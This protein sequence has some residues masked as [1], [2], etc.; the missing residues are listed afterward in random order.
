MAMTA[1]SLLGPDTVTEVLEERFPCVGARDPSLIQISESESL[2][3]GVF[4][5][6]EKP[7][8]RHVQVVGVELVWNGSVQTLDSLRLLR[9]VS[10][11]TVIADR[12]VIQEALEWKGAQVDVFARHLEF[13]GKGSISTVPE[14]FATMAWSEF[15]DSDNDR[16]LNE[17]GEI[18][19]K[20]GRDGQAGGTITLNVGALV[21]P[22]GHTCFITDGAPGE[23]G[24]KGGLRPH[25][26]FK[27]GPATKSVLPVTFD[28]V[29]TA[30]CD[31]NNTHNDLGK[32]SV[33]KTAY[34]VGEDGFKKCWSKVP[35][36]YT[37]TDV[38]LGLQ[39]QQFLARFQ[40]TLFV[41]G[42]GDVD[43]VRHDVT[44]NAVKRNTE[45]FDDMQLFKNTVAPS[46][47]EDAYPSG[48]AGRGGDAG[49]I[50]SPSAWLEALKGNVVQQKGGASR[51]S[52]EIAGGNP[53][54]PSNYALIAMTCIQTSIGEIVV[55][56]LH[57]HTSSRKAGKGCKPVEGAEGNP[58]SFKADVDTLAWLEPRLLWAVA[59]YARQV[60][61]SGHR[62]QAWNIL[63]P[64]W[65]VLVS[66]DAP[67]LGPDAAASQQ[68]IRTLVQNYQQNLDLYGNPP[69]WVPRFSTESYLKTYQVERRFSCQFLAVMDKAVGLMSSM[70]QGQAMLA[71]M[72]EQT[73]DVIEQIRQDLF[74]SYGRYDEARDELDAAGAVLKTAQKSLKSLEARAR[75]LGRIRESDKAVLKAVFDISGAVLEAIPVYQPM[76]AAV[77]T[78]VKGVGEYVVEA[79]DKHDGDEPTDG[80]EALE[81]IGK[82]VGDTLDANADAFK[83]LFDEHLKEKYKTKLDPETEDLRTQVAQLHGELGNQQREDNE[84]MDDAYSQVMQ[85]PDLS[86]LLNTGKDAAKL[87]VEG[88]DNRANLQR[89]IEEHD[90][91]ITDLDSF[92]DGRPLDGLQNELCWRRKHNLRQ[93]RAKLNTLLEAAQE[94][95]R[96]LEMEI[97]DA[98][99]AATLKAALERKK[100]LAD[101]QDKLD[102]LIPKLGKK[103][104]EDK[105]KK[106]NKTFSKIVDGTTG[107]VKGAAEIGAS[108]SK[109][110]RGPAPDGEAVTKAKDKFLG[111]ELKGEYDAVL[112][113][114]AEA[115]AKLASAFTTLQQCNQAIATQASDFAGAVQCSVDISRNRQAFSLGL[116][117]GLKGAFV[118][119]QRQAQD[120]MAYYLYLFRRAFAYEF[121][122]S[123]GEAVANLN[124][125]T[126][127]IDK[128]LKNS[129]AAARRLSK[130]NIDGDE[131]A[132]TL[133]SVLAEMEG[134]DVSS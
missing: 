125:L 38:R 100:Q 41:S 124:T 95:A 68:I 88:A 123:A 28:A 64:Y 109:V 58:G 53:G 78:I 29:K 50:H 75:E 2:A 3:P 76:L 112:K 87:L 69:G 18:M 10:R 81:E 55:P 35:A 72:A 111:N 16:P 91:L 106:Q 46:D 80:W 108:M 133:M 6:L 120:R 25:K 8:T 32:L 67:A 27:D 56:K 45:I 65:T 62:E 129:D 49:D 119:M 47:G 89:K 66:E 15:R 101:K 23:M 115:K 1:K 94:E 127:R 9:D 117:V 20:A 131:A 17:E 70:S 11:M 85:S 126:E 122:Q 36:G 61:A 118:A 4:N 84:T 71:I 51:T 48:K 31:T 43:L 105:I 21:I 86:E 24:E 34:G 63:K 26:P 98:T 99:R 113:V 54:T 92:S 44:M 104:A 74:A 93:A 5:T 14:P 12:I 83:D 96:D 52:A 33:W 90:L 130:T 19:A 116:D 40:S 132:F 77:G 13:R 107:I 102:K 103:D 30:V 42:K 82:V 128:W 110:V 134:A 97:V 79:T 39:F 7:V 121:C 59:T 37:V 73:E 60:C 114:V 22:E 57:V